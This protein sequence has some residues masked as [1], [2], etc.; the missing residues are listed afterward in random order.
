MDALARAVNA[1]HHARALLETND[2]TTF[3]SFLP[4]GDVVRPAAGEHVAF[5]SAS[6]GAFPSWRVDRPEARRTDGS[7]ADLR[8]VAQSL[9]HGSRL[10]YDCR[11]P[12]RG[13]WAETL[14]LLRSKAIALF[15]CVDDDQTALLARQ[16]LRMAVFCGAGWNV[17]GALMALPPP[18]TAPLGR[19]LDC[20]GTVVAAAFDPATRCF[21]FH[22]ERHHLASA[23]LE[24][25]GGDLV[26]AADDGTVAS[27]PAADCP[28]LSLPSR[29]FQRALCAAA[30][31]LISQ[32][33][34]PVRCAPLRLFFFQH[35]AQPIT[36][37]D[38]LLTLGEAVPCVLLE[39]PPPPLNPASEDQLL[40]FRARWSA[41]CG[42]SLVLHH[43]V[44]LADATGCFV[45]SC[46]LQ[47][48]SIWI[49]F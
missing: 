22:T 28:A 38:D 31:E 40:E 6:D 15:V 3:S 42:S 25:D 41:V 33:G 36:T 18:P 32:E 7:A 47:S 13:G 17:H 14:K 21:T 26:A 9:P 24:K 20:D 12:P 34:F 1:A 16:F 30:C 35:P 5:V 10:V 4:L 29:L 43:V 48:V 8:A 45:S 19:R 23:P 2:H 46:S 49:G 39:H 37:P 11:D 27:W 44:L